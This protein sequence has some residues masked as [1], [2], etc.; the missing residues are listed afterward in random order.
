[1]LNLVT[2][3]EILYLVAYNNQL[4]RLHWYREAVGIDDVTDF[5]TDFNVNEYTVV[6]SNTNK[7]SYQSGISGR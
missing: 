7:S 2:Y 4:V 6:S 5:K 1:M 3:N